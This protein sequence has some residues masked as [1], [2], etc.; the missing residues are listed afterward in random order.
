MNPCPEMVS[1]WWKWH[2]PVG[3]FIGI[4]GLLSVLVPLFRSWNTIPRVEKAIWTGAMFILLLL[5]LRTIYLDRSDH[6]AEQAKARCEQLEQFRNIAGQLTTAIQDNERH[7]DQTLAKVDDAINTETGGDSYC[8][9]DFSATDIA[10]DGRQLPYFYL[11]PY[12]IKVGKYPVRDI[13]ATVED[14]THYE[15]VYKDERQKDDSVKLD[16][17]TADS[18]AQY[19]ARKASQWKATLGSLAVPRRR[20]GSSVAAP[21]G[22]V[23]DFEIEIDTFNSRSWIERVT[24]RFVNGKWLEALSLEHDGAVVMTKVDQ[25]FPRTKGQPDVKWLTPE[26]HLLKLN[27]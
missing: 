25:G 10:T 7:F 22:P 17:V 23:Q 14:V 13:V 19:Q 5:E 26:D 20:V 4:L 1:H 27:P 12:L 21:D 16:A 2:P 11:I 6:D 8:Y 9:I 15:Q 18:L 3:V 24:L